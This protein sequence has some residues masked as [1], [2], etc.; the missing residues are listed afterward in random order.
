MSNSEYT[1]QR[2]SAKGTERSYSRQPRRSA[3]ERAVTAFA[4]VLLFAG[5]GI[6]AWFIV[7]QQQALETQGVALQ[8]ALNRVDQLE[9]RTQ[10][11]DEAVTTSGQDV[12]AAL[13]LWEDEIRK[14]WDVSNKRNKEWINDNTSAIARNAKSIE[15]AKTAQTDSAQALEKR[16]DEQSEQLVS[17]GRQ[18]RDATDKANESMSTTVRFKADIEK[19]VVENESAIRDMDKFRISI[20]SRLLEMERRLQNSESSSYQ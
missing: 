17:F 18:T 13:N 5:L 1:S 6:A 7:V 16:I 15:A 20:N 14:L 12:N 3:S 4:I 10:T 2:I 19:R 9:A 11:T 8:D